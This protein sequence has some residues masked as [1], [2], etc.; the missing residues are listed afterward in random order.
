M[1]SKPTTTLSQ[2]NAFKDEGNALFAQGEMFSIQAA[3]FLTN[4]AAAID[5]YSAAIVLEPENA[6]LWSNRAA[7]LV[8][9]GQLDDALSDA[10]KFLN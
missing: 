9:I 10:L 4:R 6:F 5:K 8:R 3:E 2:A 7:A 1:S